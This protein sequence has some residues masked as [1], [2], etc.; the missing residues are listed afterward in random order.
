VQKSIPAVNV[1]RMENIMPGLE[2]RAHIVEAVLSFRMKPDGVR[3]FCFFV[4]ACSN[5]AAP[6]MKLFS[7][8]KQYP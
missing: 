7:G 3:K 4:F 5:D 1:M 8:I 2:P 6:N